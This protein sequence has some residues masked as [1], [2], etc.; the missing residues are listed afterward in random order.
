MPIQKIFNIVSHFKFEVGAAL[1]SSK[2]LTN[3]LKGVSDQAKGINSQFK[4]MFAST[5][6]NL[7]GG[8]AG[9]I[10]FFRNAVKASNDFY[11]A[12]RKLSTVMTGNAKFFKTPMHDFNKNMKISKVILSDMVKEADKFG[13]SINE[14]VRTVNVLNPLLI[15]KG[16]AGDNFKQTRKLARNLMMGSSLFGLSPWEASGQLQTLVQGNLGNP[17]QTLWRALNQ[18]APEVF[19]GMSVGSFNAQKLAKRV[20]MLNKAF[21]KFIDKP[22]VLMVTYIRP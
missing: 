6:L 8:Q 11:N 20:E 15:P 2:K 17:N 1:A 16:A 9:M 18:E 19:K 14:F 3:H 7:T 10:G 21:D 5:A 13:I 4:V 22:E 12:Q